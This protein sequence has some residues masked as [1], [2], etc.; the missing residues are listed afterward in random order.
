M[1]FREPDF[2]LLKDIHDI[3]IDEANS[4]TSHDPTI[5]SLV[6]NLLVSLTISVVTK[7]EILHMWKNGGNPLGLQVKDAPLMS[8]SLLGFFPLDASTG[9]E[10][11]TCVLFIDFFALVFVMT[12]F[13]SDEKDDEIVYDTIKRI[14]SRMTVLAKERNQFHPFLYQNYAENFQD[15]FA[16]YGEENRKRL[17]Q[18]QKKYDPED[19]F[20]RLQA[21]YFKV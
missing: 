14:L 11:Y 12:F 9:S 17:R 10:R 8:T 5:F 2:E 1:T 19:V 3:F 7:D 15:V 6:H 20:Q 4:F 16:G 21:G 13:W 18:I